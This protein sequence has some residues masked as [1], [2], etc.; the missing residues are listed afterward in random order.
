MILALS[1]RLY[2]RLNGVYYVALP[3]NKR[4]SMKTKMSQDVYFDKK[5]TGVNITFRH[6]RSAFN[7]AV[8]RRKDTP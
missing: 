2:Q 1:M 5:A 3:G 4:R 7:K 8:A 6:L